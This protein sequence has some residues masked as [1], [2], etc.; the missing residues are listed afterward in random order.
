MARTLARNVHVDGEYFEAGSTPE[1]K[2]ADQ[3][4]NPNAWG[5]GDN[6]SD[7]DDGSGG[8]RRSRRSDSE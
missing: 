5:E 8:R 4:T 6:S 1:K 7:G 3:I 2:Y